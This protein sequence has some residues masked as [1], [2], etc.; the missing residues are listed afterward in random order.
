LLARAQQQK[1]RDHGLIT[2]PGQ[3]WCSCCPV[4]SSFFGSTLHRT[5]SGVRR[6]DR[7]VVTSTT[8]GGARR[9]P[10]STTR[11]SRLPAR[12]AGARRRPLQ[13]PSPAACFLLFAFL[14]IRACNSLGTVLRSHLLPASPADID[15][16]GTTPHYGVASRPWS[17]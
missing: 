3:R 6:P 12:R 8:G 4:L 13:T 15:V 16:T 5:G 9:P 11:A 1:R 17:E 14:P 7:G 2:F 10:S